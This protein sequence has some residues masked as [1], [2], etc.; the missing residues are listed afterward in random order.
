MHD[1]GYNADDI[2]VATACGYA[3]WEAKY[4]DRQWA[5]EQ[6]QS[7]PENTEASVQPA[8]RREGFPFS[9]LRL[10]EIF[11]DLF[12]CATRHFDNTGRYL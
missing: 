4:I 9:I 6:L 2:A 12:E 7:E 8:R 1:R 3:A 11:E 5:Q 10:K